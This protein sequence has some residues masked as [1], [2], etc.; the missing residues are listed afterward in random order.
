MAKSS[1]V[2]AKAAVLSSDE[3]ERAAQFAREPF[4]LDGEGP[5]ALAPGTARRRALDAATAEIEAG[6][7]APTIEWRRNFSL[8][9]GLERLLADEPPKLRDGAE[10]SA[11]QID[12]LSGTLAELLAEQ[13]RAAN[14]RGNGAASTAALAR[15]NAAPPTEES[16]PPNGEGSTALEDALDPDEEPQDWVDEPDADEETIEEAPEDPGAERQ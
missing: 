10:L 5:E 11:H 15:S 4:L 1:E 16:A 13:E 2:A 14:G 12:A 8:L 3:I 6:A 9:L 7:E